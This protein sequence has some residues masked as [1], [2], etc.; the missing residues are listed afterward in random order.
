MFNRL[1]FQFFTSRRAR[2]MNRKF[3]VFLSL[4]LSF[5]LIPVLTSAQNCTN[6]I[7]GC[8]KDVNTGISMSYTNII[9]KELQ[10]GAT[11][12]SS[13][14]FQIHDLCEGEITLIVYNLGYLTDTFSIFIAQD[15]AVNLYLKK[16]AYNINEVLVSKEKAPTSAQPSSFLNE[17]EILQ[18]SNKNLSNLLE[19]IVGV[20][21]LK[22]GN[23]ISKPVVHGLFGNRLIIL[24]NGVVQSGQQWG[25]DHSPEIDPLVA[26]KIS[27]IKGA[28][29]LEHQGSSLGGF[30]LVE[31]NQ[32]NKN[33]KLNGRT[34]YYFESNGFG[35]GLNLQ[36]EMNHPLLAWKITGTL[37][38]S[39]DRHSPSYFLRNTGNQEANIAIQ[40]EK[41]FSDKWFTKLYFSS[42]NTE[43]GILRGSHIGNLTDLRSA[44][45]QEIPFF[46]KPYFSYALEAPFQRVGHHLLKLN[47]RYYIN[48][49][50]YIDF[51]YAGQLNDRKEFDVRRG[52]ASEKPALSLGQLT[53][54]IEG[55]Y[56]NAFDNGFTI[57]TGI[58]GR[59]ID[60]T[61]RSETGV[62]PLIPDYVSYEVGTFLLFTKRYKNLFLEFGGRY[63]FM[64]QAVAAISTDLPRKIIRYNNNFHNFSALVGFN[65][66][67]LKTLKLALNLGYATRNPSINELY[68]NGLHQGVSGIEEG[69]LGLQIEQALKTTLGIDWTIKK[70]FFIE[71]LLYHQWI[72][73]YIYLNPQEEIRLTIRGAFPVYKYE[74]TLAQIYGLDFSATWHITKRLNLKAQYSYLR[75]EDLGNQLPLVYMPANNLFAK[76]SYVF[77]TVGFFKN[78]ALELNNKYVFKQSNLRSSQDFTP[79]PN[80]YNLLGLRCSIEKDIKN[81]HLK[82]YARIDN[83]LN[84][85]YRD[86]LNRQ[87]Y[88]AD[89]LGINGTLGLSLTF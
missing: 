4:F 38:K 21:T 89:A 52:R 29:A 27:V 26:N 57:K 24:N 14:C 23:G 45:T 3:V 46:T 9:V 81:V 71:A 22:N 5:C 18:N 80:A 1:L 10:K 15:T 77:P 13:G 44:L 76:V 62:L 39:G 43:I 48:S 59:F 36:L 55:K 73:N 47:S 6:T 32:I 66:Q 49:N 41:A 75:G 2:L 88:F 34:N 54:A 65:Y 86:Y 33:K 83:L 37:K 53:N 30:I 25:N 20:S 17:E 19:N 58:Q 84:T 69:D 56:F 79:V 28:A 67:A 74:Q 35:H 12:D 87:R 7:S 51:T 31:P 64:H 78:L 60:N 11:S 85:K 50:Q 42:F 70:T 82:F 68:S 72:N 61:N 16:V 8:I 63:D 40:L